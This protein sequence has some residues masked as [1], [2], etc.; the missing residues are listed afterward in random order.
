[1]LTDAEM[2]VTRRQVV[3]GGS[4]LVRS[5]VYHPAFLL[6]TQQTLPPRPHSPSRLRPPQHKRLQPPHPQR[7]LRAHHRSPNSSR[8]ST[9]DRDIIQRKISSARATPSLTSLPSRRSFLPR[10]RIRPRYAIWHALLAAGQLN[11]RS[12]G[13]VGGVV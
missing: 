10:L 4:V 7:P 8:R 2:A 13:E 9:R 12:E 11:M 5:P 6:L 3:I 1:M